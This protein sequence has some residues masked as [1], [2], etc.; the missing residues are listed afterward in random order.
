[1]TT[2]DIVKLASTSF[3]E[4]GL[5]KMKCPKCKSV[6]LHAG[7]NLKTQVREYASVNCAERFGIKE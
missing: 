2:Q 3:D 5:E 6:D 7:K 1:M 4:E